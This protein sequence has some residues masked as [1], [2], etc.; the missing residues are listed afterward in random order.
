[1]LK[2]NLGGLKKR[3]KKSLATASSG[4]REGK[5]AVSGSWRKKGFHSTPSIFVNYMY[6]HTYIRIVL[7]IK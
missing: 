7:S 2:G 5:T 3:E 1:M 4:G 6:M